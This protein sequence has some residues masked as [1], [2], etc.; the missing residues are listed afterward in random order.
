[1]PVPLD[2]HPIHQG[3][4]TMKYFVTSDRNVYDRCIMHALSPDGSRQL[5]A[6]LGVY[7]H[8]GVIDCYVATRRGRT[9]HLA[10]HLGR[11]RATTACARRSG[12]CA[13]R[14]SRA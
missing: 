12:P 1:M 4:Q 13:S 5:A 8:V 2:E 7:P 14:S 9:P 3:P 11:A 6:G 10:A